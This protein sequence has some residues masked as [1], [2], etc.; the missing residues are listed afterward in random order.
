[1]KGSTEVFEI[2][3]D[4]EKGI[5]ALIDPELGRALGPIG[6]GGEDGVKVL[7]M[8]AGAHG[9]DV[10]KVPQG[11]LEARWDKFVNDLA[12]VEDAID[13][14]P[15][16][17]HDDTPMTG[18]SPA[19]TAIASSDTA[20]ASDDHTA[21]TERETSAAEREAAGAPAA[22]DPQPSD[23]DRPTPITEPKA[24]NVICPTCDGWRT[25]PQGEAEVQCPTCKGEGE[26]LAAQSEPGDGAAG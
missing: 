26:I 17:Q 16:G 1:M 2:I 15:D 5:S 13:H 23:T 25:I 20:A 4:A 3:H 14:K 7:E 11:L 18:G 9:V 19:G 21:A 6:M 12:D 22:P 10:T 24:G 8:F